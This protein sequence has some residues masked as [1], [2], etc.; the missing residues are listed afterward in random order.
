MKR[1]FLWL[2][3]L[4]PLLMSGQRNAASIEQEVE[5]LRQEYDFVLD[6]IEQIP[7]PLSARSLSGGNWGFGAM[8]VDVFERLGIVPKRDVFVYIFDTAGEYDHKDLEGV[9]VKELASNWTDDPF[10]RDGH[11]HGTHCAGTVGGR[12]PSLPLGIAT[13]L[14]KYDKLHIIPTKV[15]NTSGAGNFSWIDN[16]LYKHTN[17]NAAKQIAAGG[18]VVYSF[19][20]GG[21]RGCPATTAKLLQDAQKLGVII[22]GAAGNSGAEGVGCPATSS[23]AAIAAIDS[24]LKKA[25]FST[26][27][28]EVR[29][30]APGVGIFSTLPGDSYADWNGTSM[31]TPHQAGFFAL[32]LSCLPDK[33]PQE[34]VSLADSKAYDLGDKGRDKLYGF[35]L[36]RL[37]AHFDGTP[38]PDPKP[39]PEPPAP[40]TPPTPPAPEPE[41]QPLRVMSI[42]VPDTFPI[43][44]SRGT[45]N[46]WRTAYMSFSIS[47]PTTL[48][49]EVAALVIGQK[50]RSHFTRLGYVLRPQD[51]EYD[52]MYW[53]AFFF[54]LIE[55]KN[56]GN[57]IR[58]NQVQLHAKG[59]TIS[60]AEP[61][62]QAK[63]AK[64]MKAKKQGEVFFVF[65]E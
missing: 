52:L 15:L 27:G 18:A 36:T 53:T 43:I 13:Y 38:A 7:A 24:G 14:R 64:A 28:P 32:L 9:E 1:A 6:P 21:G 37:K 3:L 58:V 54:E 49:G 51:D 50:V 8:E 40:P 10:L 23:T 12:H 56:L 61:T 26:T 41:P 59:V 39:D 11:G 20:L 60:Q 46:K 30:A 33:T 17:P 25:S 65:R 29:Y 31:A 34:I 45:E 47:Y 44:W 2:L 63:P 62:K 35:G 57:N 5:R 16:A 4:I 42:S 55:K 19:S 48:E 22:V